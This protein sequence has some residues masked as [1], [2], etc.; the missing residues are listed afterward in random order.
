[1]PNDTTLKLVLTH[2]DRL[3][4]WHD[5]TPDLNWMIPDYHRLQLEHF[6]WKETQ[7]VGHVRI[8]EIGAE[9][10]R[11][12]LEY[13]GEHY[14][15]VN[16]DDPTEVDWGHET[17]P[18]VSKPEVQCDIV[19]MP[20]PNSDFDICIATEVFE[21]LLDPWAAI[22]E[23]YRV[24]KPGGKGLFTT[25]FMWPYH[26]CQRYPDLWRFTGDGWRLLCKDFSSVRVLPTEFTEMSPIW[27]VAKHEN[28]GTR[29]EVRMATGY[30]VSATK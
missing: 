26:G 27:E 16:I 9:G 25:P 20:F 5:E 17:P 30:L 8:L 24:L 11:P 23:V 18:G 19:N 3:G 2:Y 29:E 10:R 1:M 15:T 22:K 12:Y 21:H 6:I 13:L 14:V 4:K 7:N 28:M